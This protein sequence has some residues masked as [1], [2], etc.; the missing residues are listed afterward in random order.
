MTGNLVITIGRECGSG[1]R[2]IGNRLAEKLNIKC[3]DKE[4]LTLAAKKSGLCEETSVMF[5]LFSCNGQLFNGRFYI[6]IY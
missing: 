1:G 3:Y 4:L 2:L 5:S 6:I